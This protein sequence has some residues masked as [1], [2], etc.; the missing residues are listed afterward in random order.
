MN[1]YTR[2]EHTQNARF[3]L[4]LRKISLQNKQDNDET[5]KLISYPPGHAIT[6]HGWYGE[7][8]QWQHRGQL[9]GRRFGSAHV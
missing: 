8:A 9:L 6:G 4:P 5:Q 7:I 3:F 1:A 2:R